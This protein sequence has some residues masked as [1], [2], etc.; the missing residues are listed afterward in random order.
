MC[1]SLAYPT[2]APLGD[3]MTTERAAICGPV[4]AR[5]E[6]MTNI[7]SKGL[8]PQLIDVLHAL[9][10]GQELLSRKVRNARL[11][12]SSHMTPVVGGCPQSDPSDF[13]GPRSFA[14]ASP[15]GTHRES[16]SDNVELG[17]EPT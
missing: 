5:G 13:A 12:H 2:S 6:D 4:T 1:S 7:S 3:P 17:M 15:V 16:P 14:G 10:E 11:E 8:L 9:T